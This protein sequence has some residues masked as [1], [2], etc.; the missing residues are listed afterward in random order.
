MKESNTYFIVCFDNKSLR[1]NSGIITDCETFNPM[2]FTETLPRNK[3]LINWKR[4]TVKEESEVKKY[5]EQQ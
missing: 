2:E 5:M 1:Y 3:V 4:L